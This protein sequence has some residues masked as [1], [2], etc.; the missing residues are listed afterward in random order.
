M[1]SGRRLIDLRENQNKG[2][3]RLD[4][5]SG[6]RAFEKGDTIFTPSIRINSAKSRK[7]LS[8]RCD[9]SPKTRVFF[10]PKSC[11]LPVSSTSGFCPRA[12]V[13]PT[14]STSKRAQARQG[15]TQPEPEIKFFPLHKKRG[16]KNLLL[17]Y[18]PPFN[19]SSLRKATGSKT[20][21]IGRAISDGAFYALRGAK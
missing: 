14:P 3:A 18:K 7:T 15:A 10:M 2:N 9:L 20:Q 5:S 11:D 12:A 1:I 6:V 19:A 17:T 4:W 16:E 13:R 8:F 21:S